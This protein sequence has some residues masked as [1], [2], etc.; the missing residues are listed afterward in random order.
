MQHVAVVNCAQQPVA[1]LVGDV[2]ASSQVSF[3]FRALLEI[4]LVS[5]DSSHLPFP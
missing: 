2:V 4:V 1:G 5:T 3:G